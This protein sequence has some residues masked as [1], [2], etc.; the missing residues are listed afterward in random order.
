M[1]KK[2]GIMIVIFTMSILMISCNKDSE[3]VEVSNKPKVITTMFVTYDFAREIGGENID[4]ELLIPP[5]VEIHSFEPSP[6]DM[7][8]LSEADVFI[9]SGDEM[10]PWVKQTIES[11]DNDKLIVIDASKDIQLMEDDE[12]ENHQG[13][14]HQ[15]NPHI[16]TSPLLAKKMVSNVTEG[17]KIADKANESLYIGRLKEYESKLDE[18]DTSYREMVKNSNRND[19]VFVGHFALNYLLDEYGIDYL[20]TTES[21]THEA[22]SSPQRIKAIIDKIDEEDIEYI[23]EEE[24]SDGIISNRILEERDVKV[25]VLNGMH[26]ITKSEF[27]SGISYLDIQR[28]N[29]DNLEKGLK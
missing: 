24:L 21:M 29:I 4:L 27:E 9:Y 19:I 1:K 6:K 22:E 15:H 25:L 11:V 13:H 23:Y 5:G 3:F 7:V 12:H 28:Q 26:N 2:I 16:W 8:K 10:E 20:A 17:L 18:I 14:N